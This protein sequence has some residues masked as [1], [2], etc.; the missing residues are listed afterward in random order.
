[1]RSPF[2][3][4][5]CS[6]FSSILL[7]LSFPPFDISVLAWIS[8]IPFF[9]AAK[10]IGFRPVFITSYIL[11]LFFFGSL[12]YWL[13]Y[14]TIFGY[15]ILVM[16]L[17]IYFGIFGLCSKFIIDR[18]ENLALFLIPAVWVVLEFL[19]TK[20]FTGFGWCLLGYS[21]YKFLELVQISNVFG[22][23]V[24]SFLIMMVN[25]FLFLVLFADRKNA[26]KKFLIVALILVSVILYGV[27]NIKDIKSKECG[28]LE[29]GFVQ[30]NIP[31]E[32][33]WFGGNEDEIVDKY[34]G[35]SN[36]LLK[37]SPIPHLVI[38][39]ETAL[40]D[41][42]NNY[43]QTRI[44]KIRNFAKDNGVWLLTGAIT[45]E[46][47]GKTKLYYNSAVLF[48]DEGNAVG[49]Y[50]KM[51]LV[52]F[53]EYMPLNIKRSLPFLRFWSS[54]IGDS[55]KGSQ[56]TVLRVDDFKIGVLICFEDVF[57]YMAREFSNLG[58]DFFVNITNDAW[59]GKS[60]APMQHLQHSVFRAIENSKYLVRVANTGISCVIEPSGNVK[61][62]ISDSRGKNIFVDG[63]G[64]CEIRKVP[65]NT[66]FSRFGD[67]FV[68]IC[69]LFI[70]ILGFA[71]TVKA[72]VKSDKNLEIKKY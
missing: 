29:V 36:R 28:L 31:Q 72:L 19:R 69:F 33:K 4:L 18:A 5:V 35:L 13:N 16:Y 25:V 1:M 14:V 48:N 11:G 51:H 37:R 58:A 65:K 21:Q 53:G 24:V 67:F 42:V 63:F 44:L 62:I 52:P 70:G 2:C 22:V 20:L 9:Y 23:W 64:K 54:I 40:P 8:F 15:L 43:E 66:L 68:W 26:P 39:P 57:G 3:F 6:L 59:F 45:S 34:L 60:S 27:W 50:D 12:L 41:V 10:K 47:S 71:M 46:F 38:W 17:G 7:V 32:E 61:N 49:R 56:Y 30:G 55:K